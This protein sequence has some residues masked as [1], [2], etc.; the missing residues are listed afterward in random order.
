MAF[1]A[2]ELA[3]IANT[4]MDFYIK[5]QA[6]VQTMQERP[7]LNALKGTKKTFPGGKSDIRRNVKGDYSS[8][9]AGYTHNDAW[10]TSTRPTTSRSTTRGKSFTRASASPTP[11]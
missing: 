11:S 1:T 4:T 3:N 6:L 8:A 10:A 5:G 9:F 7:L 2:A